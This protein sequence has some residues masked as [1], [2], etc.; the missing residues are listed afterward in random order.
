MYYVGFSTATIVA[1]LILFKGFNTTDATETL[2][3]LSGFIVTFLGVHILNFSRKSEPPLK[4]S[5]RDALEGGLMNPRLSLQGGMSVD[6]WIETDHSARGGRRLQNDSPQSFNVFEDH[7]EEVVS[8]R[9]LRADDDTDDDGD[10]D[11]DNDIVL[12]EEIPLNQRNQSSMLTKNMV[13]RS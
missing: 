13:R 10:D 4:Q 12:S 3:L 1:S 7:P 6:G 2:S 5:G 11:D 8:L 9:K